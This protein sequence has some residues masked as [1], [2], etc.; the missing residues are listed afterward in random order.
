M[1]HISQLRYD[2]VPSQMTVDMKEKIQNILKYKI[3]K[4]CRYM[5]TCFKGRFT[6]MNTMFCQV[7]IMYECLRNLVAYP[8]TFHD[9]HFKNSHI[10]S[11]LLLRKAGLSTVGYHILK[12]YT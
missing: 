10:F 4:L 12:I 6:L 1:N 8:G 9:A 7:V 11:F 2:E 5:P 3:K